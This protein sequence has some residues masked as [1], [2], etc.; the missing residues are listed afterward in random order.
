MLLLEPSI[1]ENI[2]S[3]AEPKAKEAANQSIC[4]CSFNAQQLSKGLIQ[5]GRIHNPESLIQKPEFRFSS[6]ICLKYDTL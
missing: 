2:L 4:L 3:Y 1:P 5:G 6:L